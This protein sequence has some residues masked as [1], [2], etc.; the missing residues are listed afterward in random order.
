M[1]N[2]EKYKHFC[3]EEENIPIFSQY[4]W[5]EAVAKEQWDVVLYE[6]GNRIV[7]SMVYFLEK[8][9]HGMIISKAP[10]TQNNG[11]YIKYPCDL[12]NACR[13]TYEE[14]AMNAIIDQLEALDIQHFEQNFNYHIT[15]WLPFYW[16]GYK[17]TTRYTYQIEDTNDLCNVVSEFTAKLRWD[18]KKAKEVLYVKK[19]IPMEE[20]YEVN[21]MSFLRQKKEV[22][23]TLQQLE[24]LDA[25]AKQRQA[26]QSL[27]AYDREGRLN[28]VA[29][30]V[31]DNQCV[32]YLLS[33][34]NPELRCTQPQSLLILEGL[35]LAHDLGKV[36]DFEGSMLP[37]VE[38][39]IR[40]FGGVQR[41]YF[42]ISKAY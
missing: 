41:P 31:W 28:G 21:A 26:C 5:M 25:W 14:R 3:E 40:K 24:R 23:F 12:K 1:T 37:H 4:W 15:N 29:Y 10:F 17:E 9:E 7:A 34:S 6:T 38:P 35:Q 13:L 2:K 22:P 39:M 16:R 11:V 32:Y 18:L 42:R 19:E 27:G 20:F 8:K 30:Y 33:G 36:F